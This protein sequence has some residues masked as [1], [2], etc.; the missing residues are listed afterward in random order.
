[1]MKIVAVGGGS[2]GFGAAKSEVTPLNREM[3]RLTGKRR[4]R[5]IFLPTAS[6]DDRAYTR[7]V[8]SHFKK[9]G[10]LVETLP[11]WKNPP[12]FTQM[13]KQILGADLIYVGGGNTLKMIGLWKR[14]GLLALLHKAAKRGQVLAGTSA[15][16]ICWFAAGNSD[17]RKYKNPKAGLIK[18]T[19]LG[20]VDAM[21]CP[22]YDVE[23]DRKPELK[24][25]TRGFS[26]V[27][28]AL[29]NCAALE[30]VGER[31][32]VIAS[33]PK[34]GGYKVYWRRGEFFTTAI[35]PQWVSL[36]NLLSKE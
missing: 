26:K 20:L 15:G 6:L 34:A 7:A 19:G 31:C 4:P 17:S 25:M 1:M 35:G 27:A 5:M 22:H 18:V 10:C 32:R 36:T 16:A 3:I 11:L 14:L 33:T 30:V 12:P 29:D 28:I 13:K 21:A 8:E 23:K 2:I 24:R 9:L